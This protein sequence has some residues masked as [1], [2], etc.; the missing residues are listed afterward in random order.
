M[1]EREAARRYPLSGRPVPDIVLDHYQMK[2]IAGA[3]FAMEIERWVK[4][5]NALLPYIDVLF[6][7]QDGNMM[8]GFKNIHGDLMTGNQGRFASVHNDI[9]N[10]I[11]HFQ[12]LPNLPK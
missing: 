11:T 4:D 6:L 8:K 2:F 9:E 10:P 3:H 5:F 1:I 12:P 7:T